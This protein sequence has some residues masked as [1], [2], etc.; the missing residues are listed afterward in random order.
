[1]NFKK[2]Y[3]IIAVLA[4]LFGMIPLEAHG[5]DEYRNDFSNTETLDELT[6]RLN[7]GEVYTENGELV[8]EGSTEYPPSTRVIFPFECEGE[9]LFELDVALGEASSNTAQ[10]GVFFGADGGNEYKVTISRNGA[11]TVFCVMYCQSE[12][13]FTVLAEGELECGDKFRLQTAVSEGVLY[14][15]AG[16]EPLL[17]CGVPYPCVGRAGVE[18]RLITSRFDNISLKNGRADVKKASDSYNTTVYVPK[19]GIVTPPVVIERDNEKNSQYDVNMKRQAITVYDVRLYEKALYVFSGTKRIGTLSE[20]MN[21]SK[22]L[23][24]PAFSVSDAECAAAL[25]VYISENGIKDAFVISAKEEH[26]RTVKASNPLI[27]G[28]I[29]ASSAI[30]VNASEL[31]KRAHSSGCNTVILPQRGVNAKTVKALKELFMTVY[32]VCGEKNTNNDIYTC[33]SSGC[34][35]IIGDADAVISYMESFT[36]MTHFG[37][38]FT[39]SYGGDE[40]A[41]HINS[42]TAVMSAAKNGADV[43][44]VDICVTDDGSAVLS[45]TDETVY[46]NQKVSIYGTTL[47]ELKKLHYTDEKISGE[48]IATLSEVLKH[49]KNE[50]PDVVIY[51]RLSDD[52]TLTADAVNASAEEYGMQSRV[53]I[54]TDKKTVAKYAQEKLKVGANCTAEVYI[55]VNA[56]DNTAVCCIESSLRAVNSAYF[57]QNIKLTKE[58]LYCTASRGIT[59]FTNN[60]R[61]ITELDIQ[62]DTSGKISVSA[63]RADGTVYDVTD[64]AEF[65]TVSGTP[66]FHNGA[67]SG[68]G[69]FAVRVPFADGYVY[70]RSLAAEETEKSEETKEEPSDGNGES[71]IVKYIIIAAGAVMVAGGL[72]FFGFLKKSSFKK[73]KE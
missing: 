31:Y 47:N 43:I 32:T 17:L 64:K 56:S 62:K 60:Q 18:A 65:V 34:D 35:G 46:L 25:S 57:P 55:P 12:E 59:V 10:C 58:L 4:M 37:T 67:V 49:L 52:R 71:N 23:T 14:V 68:Q 16:D 13:M 30:T 44:R 5:I 42:L 8:L 41:G 7:D 69:V 2:I 15:N 9:F 28:V 63:T 40:S 48:S 38:P 53:V 19:T 66:L 70:T 27:R 11:K 54:L 22:K 36:D 1:M 29:D 3:C 6:V 61:Q 20:R 24:I 33:L 39:V 26:I 51:A 72:A 21:L 73:E 45:A 50:Y